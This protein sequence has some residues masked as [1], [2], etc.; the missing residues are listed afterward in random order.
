MKSVEHFALSYHR[1]PILWIWYHYGAS[2]R[3]TLVSV[4]QTGSEN[5]QQ[6]FSGGRGEYLQLPVLS[7]ALSSN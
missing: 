4:V 1:T 6:R 5:I 2:P 7:G 3:T